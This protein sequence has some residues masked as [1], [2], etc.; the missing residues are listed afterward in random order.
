VHAACTLPAPPG[1]VRAAR[2]VLETMSVGHGHLWK[3]G[4]SV[5]AA[6]TSS[7]VAPMV[8]HMLVENSGSCSGYPQQ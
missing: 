3:V 4:V 5:H 6:C 7:L 1:F 8:S 2:E